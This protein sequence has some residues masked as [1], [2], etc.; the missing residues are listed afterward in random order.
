MEK[1]DDIKLWYFK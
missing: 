1:E